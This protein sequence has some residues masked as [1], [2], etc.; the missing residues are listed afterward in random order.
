MNQSVSRPLSVLLTQVLL[1]AP[2]FT[3]A[4][5]IPTEVSLC[6]SATPPNRCLIV[7]T[8]TALLIQVLVLI[9]SLI[10]F[11]GLQTRKHYGKWLAV[12]FL[13]GIGIAAI[14]QTNS[15]SMIYQFI[16]QGKP[17]PAPPYACWDQQDLLSPVSYSCGYDSYGGLVLRIISDA[18]PALIFGFLAMRILYSSAAKQFFHRS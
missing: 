15:F 7:P 6:L 5:A 4:I 9:I 3:S 14:A 18:L 13:I 10:T 17:F 8:L 16:T 1:I 12:S 2:V 11:W